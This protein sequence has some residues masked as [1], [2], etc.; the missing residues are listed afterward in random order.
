MDKKNNTK[1]GD[2]SFTFLFTFIY[3]LYIFIII[4]I[5]LKSVFWSRSDIP[6][7]W[8]TL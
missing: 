2:Y 8:P 4:I 3:L 1:L 6:K 5:F 7:S